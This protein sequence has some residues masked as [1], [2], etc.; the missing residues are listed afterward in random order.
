MPSSAWLAAAKS[1]IVGYFSKRPGVTSLTTLSVH[2]AERIVATSNSQQSRWCRGTVGWGY[3]S[4]RILRILPRRVL[5][6]AAVLG[7]GISFGGVAFGGFFVAT[8][9]SSHG[10]PAAHGRPAALL[11]CDQD[12]G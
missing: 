5:R 6:S 12:F 7:R 9:L 11:A 2:C 3:I 10:G 8:P 4:S 1:W